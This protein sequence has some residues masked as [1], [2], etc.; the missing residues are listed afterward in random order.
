[1]GSSSSKEFTEPLIGYK[2]PT[3]RVKM[4]Q[5]RN[6]P[7]DADAAVFDPTADKYDYL[8]IF[9]KPVDEGMGGMV[10]NDQPFGAAK[11]KKKKDDEDDESEGRRTSQED[12][13]MS[14]VDI[15]QLWFQ[16]IS[17]DEDRKKRG[18]EWLEQEWISRFRT[19][20]A[21]ELNYKL[22]FRGEVDPGPEFWQKWADHDADGNP[23]YVELVEEGVLYEKNKANEILEDLYHAGKIGPNDMAVFENEEPSKKHWSRRDRLYL[24]KRIIDE[25]FDFGVLVENDVV[26][27]CMALHDANFGETPTLEWFHQNWVYFWSAPYDLAGAPQVSMVAIDKGEGQIFLAFF[28]VVWS[29]YYKEGWDVEQQYCA[30]K[31]GTTDFEEEEADRPQ[32]VGDPQQ[33]RRLSPITNQN[34]TYYPQEKR[35][36]TQAWGYLVVLCFTSGLLVIVIASFWVQYQLVEMGMDTEAEL[37]SLFQAGLI[38]VLSRGYSNVAYYLNAKENYKTQTDYDNNLVL[39]KFGFE[40]FNNYS[41]LAITAYFKGT[42]F[43][44]IEGNEN[45]LADLKY[46]LISIFFVRFALAFTSAFGSQIN[47]V[48]ECCCGSGEDDEDEEVEN[49]AHADSRR[50][51]SSSPRPSTTARRRSRSSRTRAADADARGDRRVLGPAHGR[52]V[53]LAVFTNAG[54]VCYTTKSLKTYSSNEKL[55]FFVFEQLLLLAKMITHV[56]IPDCPPEL[57]AI[58]KR[59]EHVVDRHKNV[60]FD[61]DDDDD[62][63]GATASARATST[64]R[65]CA[66]A[67]ATTTRA[68]RGSAPWSSTASSTSRPSSRPATAT[69]RSRSQYKVACRTEIF[70]EETGVSYSRKTPGLALGMV[71]LTVLEAENIG[72]RHDPV[73]PKSCRIIVPRPRHA[74]A[75]PQVRGQRAP[76]PRCPSPRRSP[77]SNEMTE[78]QRTSGVRMVFNQSF[79]LAPIKTMKAEIYIEIMDNSK[80]VRR[81]TTTQVLSDLSNQRKQSLTLSVARPQGQ[82]VGPQE[83]AVLYVKVQFQ[84]SRILPIKRRIYMLLDEQRKLTSDRT[85]LRLGKDPEHVWDFPDDVGLKKGDSDA[86]DE[87]PPSP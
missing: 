8:I 3:D 55:F 34:E 54:I 30:V 44:C 15:E 43:Q 79:S 42:Y 29:A 74:Q 24:T 10:T 2:F 75:R 38:Q 84:Y 22:K 83:P 57:Y 53:L 36:R 51:T 50:T 59:Q 6:Y 37:M 64:G 62:D 16:A 41:A 78:E 40:I 65:P 87:E 11:K 26:K 49:P 60:V 23:I 25:Q 17:G 69:S 21:D 76:R 67:T 14:W 77:K 85:N 35:A 5:V 45:C 39:K 47:Y 81:G 72:S 32:F 68:R 18:I 12:V 13:R 19:D 56:L 70:N 4:R 52:H 33:P 28:L 63:G 7:T 9:K 48:Y 82:H 27:A 20:T 46:L 58:K 86:S 80:R 61:D 31:W 66:A 71:T 73:D 1:M